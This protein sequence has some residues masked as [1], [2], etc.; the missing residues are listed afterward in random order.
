MAPT[1]LPAGAYLKDISAWY[2]QNTIP[3]P[4]RAGES[5]PAG[6]WA[7]VVVDAGEAHLFL[8][9]AKTPLSVTRGKPALVPPETPFSLGAGSQPLRFRLLYYHE[10]VVSDP[11]ELAARLGRD[12][13]A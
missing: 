1:E 4:L 13:A 3:R 5:L 12:R 2:N 6:V 11:A 9:G 10:P 7:Q 8:N